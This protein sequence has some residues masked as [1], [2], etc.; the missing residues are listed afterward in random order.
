MRTGRLRLAAAFG[1][2]AAVVLIPAAVAQPDIEEFP[3]AGVYEGWTPLSLSS[4]SVTVFVELEGEPTT[5]RQAK[6]GRKLSPSEKAQIKAE[7]RAAQSDAKPAIERVGGRVLADYQVAINGLKVE[8]AGDKLAEL[9]ELPSVAAIREIALIEP[10]HTTSVPFIGAPAAWNGDAGFRGEDVKVAILDSGIDYTHANFGG[11]GT[12]AAYDQADSTDTLPADPTLF[13]P[14][15]PKVKGGTDLVGDN[16]NASAPPP[17]EGEPDPRVPQ[18]D[19]NP[20]DCNTGN[21]GGHGS[22]VA[23]SAAGFGVNDDGTTYEGPWDES[24]FATPGAFTIGPGVAPE[25]DLYAVRVFGCS[26]STNVTVDAIEWSVENEMDVIN[27]SLGSAFGSPDDASAIAASNAA[28]AGV[29]VV[30]SAGNSGASQYI[31]SSPATGTGTI[32][33]AASDPA[34]SFGAVNINFEGGPVTALNANGAELP[35]GSFPIKVLRNASGGVSLGCDRQEYLDQ[36]VAGTIVVTLRGVCARVARAIFAEQAG[37]VAAVM[38]NTDAGFPP[39]EGKITSNPDDGEQFE[40]TIP[41]LG[42]RGV[43]GPAATQDGDTL[44]AGDGQSATLSPTE[45]ANPNFKGFASFTSGGPRRVDSWLKPDITGPGVSILSTGVGT[46]SGGRISSG[47]S[48]SAPHVAGV[49]ALAREAHPGWSV[50][51]IK[52]S[53]VNTGDASG[54]GTAAAPFRISRGGSGLV[55]PAKAV[56]TSVVAIGDPMTATLSYGF[57]EFSTDFSATKTITLRNHGS[58]AATFNVGTAANSPFS[59]AHSATPSAP[60]IMVP[61]GGSA[62]VDVTLSTSGGAVGGSNAFKEIAG[63]VTFTPA[64]ESMNAGVSLS[65]P[66]YLVPRPTSRIKSAPGQLRFNSR[67]TSSKLNVLNQDGQVSGSADF[68]VWGLEDGN[69]AAVNANDIRAVGVQSF[70]FGIPANPNR[71]LLV[72]A[73]NTHER[74]SNAAVSEFDIPVDVDLDGTD[75]YVVVGADAGLLLG[76]GAFDGRFAVGVFSTRSEGASVLFLATAPHDSSSALLPVRT[77]QLCRT[78]EPCLDGTTNRRFAYGAESFALRSGS[79][80]DA[81]TG[82]ALFNGWSSSLS[83]GMFVGGLAPGASA[84]V[85]VSVD[86]AEWAETP[87]KGIMVVSTEN[88]SGASEAQLVPVNVGR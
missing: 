57:A 77:D 65:V 18:P 39:F 48:M 5:V 58:S 81:V 8:I 7:L 62:T 38:I 44:V 76:T 51:D 47:T 63:L 9:A 35:D 1:A 4:R 86:L 29:I 21:A 84:Q 66:Y 28:A 12:T 68:Y 75:D 73:V 25:A 31:T 33:V 17:E 34:P 13:G 80:N 78:D 37:A 74:W 52:A 22:H 14:I 3:A 64:D 67:S 79:G 41:F 42:V 69:E 24:T 30:V 60:S 23:G 55:Q 49:A 16:Y 26:G 2:V 36:N 45:I 88:A 54:V 10:D 87:A 32:S 59:S 15:A 83:Q 53:I 82:S 27:M 61:A 46:G 70:A 56:K 71:R 50:E 43:L 72:F 40:V 6:A 20:L 11:P 19:P 85:P